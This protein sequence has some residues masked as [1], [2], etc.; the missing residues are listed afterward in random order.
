MLL[1]RRRLR[2][3]VLPPCTKR[4]SVS[5]LYKTFFFFLSSRVLGFCVHHPFPFQGPLRHLCDLEAGYEDVWAPNFGGAAPG[6]EPRTSCLRVRSVTITLR[7][8]PHK[9]FFFFLIYPPKQRKLSPYPLQRRPVTTHMAPQR[10]T[11]ESARPGK[12]SL[13]I[14]D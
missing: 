3:P 11:N 13:Q 6:F 10:E 12:G 1:T 2:D 8:P 4:N 9:T 7:G 5:G 14:L